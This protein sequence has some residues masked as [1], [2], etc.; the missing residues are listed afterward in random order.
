[1]DYQTGFFKLIIGPMFSGKTTHLIKTFNKYKLEYNIETIAINHIID[2]RY[3]DN[4]IVSHNGEQINCITCNK[5]EEL[6]EIDYNKVLNSKCILIN[7]AQ[8][9]PDLYDW[10]KE[11]VENK[12]KHIYIYGLDGDFKREKF[13]EILTLIPICD[14]ITK[15]KSKCAFCEKQNGSFTLRINQNN[16]EQILVGSSDLY[17]PTCRECYN[18]Y[19]E[20]YKND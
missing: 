17:K 13:G 1:M 16:K 9:F 3:S 19:S 2:N 4:M 11:M 12:H 14:E 10:V 8:F 18:L 6:T 7:E 15:L 5:L 20:N